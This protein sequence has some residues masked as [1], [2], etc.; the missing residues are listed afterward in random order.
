MEFW[1]DYK[2]ATCT[3]A[4]TKTY[5][6]TICKKNRTE[7]I[8]KTRHTKITKLAKKASCT[9]EGYTGDVY[10]KVCGKL[11]EKGNIVEKLSHTWSNWSKLSDATVMKPEK[12]QRTCTVCKTTE[13]MEVN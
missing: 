6:C 12:Q 1:E 10:C 5:T 11:L 2:K 13:I 4:G 9:A 3:T 8:P 7:S